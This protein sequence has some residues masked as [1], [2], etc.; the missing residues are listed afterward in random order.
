MS[1][2]QCEPPF[3]GHL[4]I[5]NYLLL[6]IYDSFS[7][8]LGCF[9]HDSNLTTI[10]A[11]RGANRVVNVVSATGGAYCQRGSD[12]SVMSS[13]LQG[14]SLRLSSFWMCHNKI[15]NLLFYNFLILTFSVSA[16]PPNAGRSVVRLPP[17]CFGQRCA[18]RATYSSPRCI[19]QVHARA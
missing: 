3:H 4:R 2:Q 10:V 8:L 16:V 11:A 1:N 17:R 15:Y 18:Q 7:E 19:F 13:S 6:T 5:A 12:G 14:T 9:L